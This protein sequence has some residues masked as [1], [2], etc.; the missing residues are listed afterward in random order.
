MAFI[1]AAD[2][3]D[4]DV[5]L[6]FQRYQNYLESVREVFPKSAFKIATSD[7][8]YN[9]NDHRCLHDAQLLS[10]NIFQ[11]FGGVRNEQQT[12]SIEVTLLS[13]YEDRL[14]KLKYP[15]VT[16][17]FLNITD[18]QRGQ[19]DWRYDELRLSDHGLL[20]HEVEWYGSC[21]IGSWIIEASDLEIDWVLK[22]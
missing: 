17:Y 7:W 1:L 2:G 9:F 3:R 10:C 11:S 20:L 22:A 5:Q 14:I 6:S 13:A 21:S 18:G 8:F 16:S 4:D 19:R 12:L 15:K